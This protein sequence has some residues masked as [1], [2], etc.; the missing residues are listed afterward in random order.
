M[1]VNISIGFIRGLLFILNTFFSKMLFFHFHSI[2]SFVFSWWGWVGRFLSTFARFFL[3][4]SK[5]EWWLSIPVLTSCGD[6]ET[7]FWVDQW[8]VELGESKRWLTIPVLSSGGDGEAGFWMDEWLL[9]FGE[10]KRWLSIPVLSGGGNG[11]TS[12]WMN[13][14]LLSFSKSKWWLTIP[15]LTCC[16]NGKSSFWVNKRLAQWNS[17]C[18]SNKTKN[19]FHFVFK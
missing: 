7:G 11:K 2:Y 3:F 18:S 15:V 13:E 6:G 1:S 5:G 9:G 8:L 16:G 14:W 19:E 10:G 4:F 12:L 17:W